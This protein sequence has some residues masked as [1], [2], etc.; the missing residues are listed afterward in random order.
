MPNPPNYTEF[1]RS[2]TEE[3]YSIKDRI[4]NLVQ[5]WPTD[6]EHKEIAVKSLLRRH[7]PES[8]I[9]GRGFVVTQSESST[10]I[11]ILI[12]DAN[13]PTLFKDG[14]LL[15]VTPDAVR[16]VVEVKTAQRGTKELTETFTKLSQIENIC[17]KSTGR[18]SVFTGLFVFEGEHDDC[19]KILQGIAKSYSV[20]NRP[21]NCVSYGKETFVRYWP[22]GTEIN[23][24]EQ[25]SVWHGYKL[26]E[27]APSY[28][29]GNLIEWVG[30]GD[31]NSAGF[32]W[33]PAIGGKEQYRSHFLPPGGK[34]TV[35]W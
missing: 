20:T 19:E 21:I 9:V 14:D 2:I 5:H 23:S 25:G 18:D 10:Q 29:L 4:R 3:L 22:R 12:V 33:F 7:L 13:K 35:Y 34:P 17:Q 11:D 16:A 28:F 6:G 15:I 31:V 32:A 30:S 24:A 8:V 27:V 1:H 26:P